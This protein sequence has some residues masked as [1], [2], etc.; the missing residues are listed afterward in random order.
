MDKTVLSALLQKYMNG[1]LTPEE[2]AH[3]KSLIMYEDEAVLI[4][5]LQNA[6]QSYVSEDERNQDSF[7]SVLSNIQQIIRPKVELRLSFASIWKVAA[8][9]LLPIFIL[10]TSYLFFKNKTIETTIAHEYQIE[11]GKG[12]RASVTLPDGTKVYLNSGS[13]LSYPASFGL[14]DRTIQLTGEAYFMVT[15]DKKSHF[16]VHTPSVKAEVLG[17]TFNLSAYP[18]QSWFE[19]AL[20][21]GSIELVSY[22]QPENVIRLIPNQKARYDRDKNQWD[23]TKTDLKVETAWKR[24]DLVFRSQTLAS[25]LKRMEMVYGVEIQ[26]EGPYPELLFTGSYHENDINVVLK[27]LQY[28]YNFTYQKAGTKVNISFE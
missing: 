6:W 11:T 5:N 1:Q 15:H 26:V 20:V 28:H 10:S 7:D 16:I 2:V 27:N 4:E 8:A 25:V 13:S 24:G 19:A 3:L 14:Y 17:T 9:I 12:E 18:T 23:V 21:E 22:D